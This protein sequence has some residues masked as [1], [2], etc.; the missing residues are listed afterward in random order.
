[1]LLAGGE[2]SEARLKSAVR[3]VAEAVPGARRIMRAGQTHNVDPKVLTEAV[4]AFFAAAEAGAEP[5]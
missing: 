2:K 4:L 1:M 5:G 3:A